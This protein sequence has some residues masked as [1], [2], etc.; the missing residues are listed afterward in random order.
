VKFKISRKV[1]ILAA[2]G[3]RCRSRH[4]QR[5]HRR[6]SEQLLPGES[7]AADQVLL[8]RKRALANWKFTQ[9]RPQGGKLNK[10]RILHSWKQHKGT[11][12][13]LNVAAVS[14]GQTEVRCVLHHVERLFNKCT[15][16]HEF[17]FEL[18]QA[19]LQVR[20][21]RIWNTHKNESETKTYQALEEDSKAYYALFPAV[22]C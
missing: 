19:G 7:T 2:A 3:A 9:H 4:C 21:R 13:I 12:C 1:G 6:H 17:L 15:F 10:S 5:S 18:G 11:Q 8:C 14:S 20:H 22:N 16:S